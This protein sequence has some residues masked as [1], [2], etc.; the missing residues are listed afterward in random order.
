VG[1][2]AVLDTVVKRKIPSPRQESTP[3]RPARSQSLYRL[4]YPGSCI[5]EVTGSYHSTVTVHPNA[6]YSSPHLLPDPYLLTIHS[7]LYKSAFKKASL[8]NH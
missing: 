2:R 3:G 1:P 7:M 8:G 5:W 4:S 6:L